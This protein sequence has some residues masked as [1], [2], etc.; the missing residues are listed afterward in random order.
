MNHTAKRSTRPP[1]R[2][3]LNGIASISGE[4]NLSRRRA[5]ADAAR[6][7]ATLGGEGDALVLKAL[8]LTLLFSA[9]TAMGGADARVLIVRCCGRGVPRRPAGGE[10]AA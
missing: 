6:P 8:L 2:T 7:L 4:I 9:I 3:T 1:R 10:H 5:L